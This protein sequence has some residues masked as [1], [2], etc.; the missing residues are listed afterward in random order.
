YGFSREQD[1]RKATASRRAI[2][3]AIEFREPVRSNDAFTPHLEAVERYNREDCVSA[4]KLRDWLEMLRGEAETNGVK[5]PRPEQKSG[6]ASEEIEDT[7]AET[8]LVMDQLLAGIPPE[9][10]D[11]SE[12]QQARWL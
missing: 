2:E 5:L 7:A 12:E 10:E 1:M 11:R 6:D 3:W 4:E 9:P 8:R